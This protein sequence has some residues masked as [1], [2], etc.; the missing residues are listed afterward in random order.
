MR[1]ENVRIYGLYESMVAAGYPMYSYRLDGETFE[2]EVSNLKKYAVVCEEILRKYGYK[3]KLD[4]DLIIKEFGTGA[5]F[6]DEKLEIELKMA[7]KHF[8]RAK[9]LAST[10]AGEGHNCYSKG[11]TIQLD[12]TADHI[13]LLQFFRYHFQDTISSMSKMH[14][15]LKMDLE[16]SFDSRV[17]PET[18]TLLKEMIKEYE[19]SPSPEFFEEIVLNV[20]LGLE[21][22]SRITLNYLQLISMYKQRKNHKMKSWRIFLDELLNETKH[23]KYLFL[24]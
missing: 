9:I 5:D 16:E 1:V 2:M 19:E 11:I 6:Y 7:M 14:K 10:G 22:T 24:E 13:F 20:P 21:L 15:L 8:K 23:F 3:E 17:R 12:L 18:I 4:W